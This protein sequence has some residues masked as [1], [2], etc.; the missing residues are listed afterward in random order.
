LFTLFT[1][2]HLP[3]EIMKPAI[4][5]CILSVSVWLCACNNQPVPTQPTFSARI[6][7]NGYGE[8]IDSSYYKVWSDS[9]WEEFYGDTT[10][11]GKT[12]TVLLQS[13]S[14]E[15]FYDLSGNYSGFELPQIYGYTI[16]MF[17]SAL[18]S[19]P[20]TMIGD[21]TY[22]AQTTFS[23][24][25][26]RYALI[27]D[28]T[29][30]DSGTVA[31]SFGLFTNCPGIQS[32]QV[33]ESGGVVVAGS[34]VVYWLA[35]GP[36]IVEQDFYDFY[37]GYLLYS[38]VMAYGVVNG[39]GWGVTLSRQY[40]SGAPSYTGRFIAPRRSIASVNRLTPDIHY[41]APLILKGI[42]HR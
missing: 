33:I 23:F 25:G 4:I 2:E 15:Y 42:I 26:I 24:Q 38:I 34:N 40:R 1:E 20:D 22:A 9:S 6:A 8:V 28:E 37:Y 30:V 35:K 39:Q 32:N 17:D 10:M 13:D 27:D 7:L 16:I 19:L 11:N 14:S 5:T 29:L 41:I 31:T 3:G 36:S 18:A 12:Y 21:L